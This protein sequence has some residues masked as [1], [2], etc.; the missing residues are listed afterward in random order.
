MT[1]SPVGFICLLGFFFKLGSLEAAPR[2]YTNTQGQKI[3]A[4]IVEVKGDTVILK[5]R[6]KDYPVPINGLSK[7]DQQFISNWAKETSSAS[8][9][10]KKMAAVLGGDFDKLR[11][12]EWPSL[13]VA[14]DDGKDYKMIENE[15]GTF[16]YQSPHFEFHIK[17]EL[18]KSVVK[19]FAR[20]FEATF[21]F[22]D[23]APLG[24]APSPS[25]SGH[26]QTRLFRTRNEYYAA[27]GIQGSG[28]VF[29]YSYRG[30]PDKPAEIKFNK[31]EIK[32]P[33][34]SLGVEDKGTRFVL[35]RDQE[36]KTLIHEI[37][38]QV[39]MRWL[40]VMPTWMSEGFAEFVESQ[41]YS[42]GRYK[43]NNMTSNIRDQIESRFGKQF[44]MVPIEKLMT[45]SSREWAAALGS[46]PQEAGRNYYSA[47]LLLSYFVLL[48]GNQK[49]EGIVG[50]LKAV[51]EGVPVKK[52][53]EDH[54]LR[55]RSY[56]EL[57]VDVQEA[58]RKAERIK[59]VF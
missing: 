8:Q 45:I 39:M 21:Q 6:G 53:T 1:R 31:A 38:H 57:A 27:G 22:L 24:L 13:V 19:E 26:F 47:N 56:E 37:V 12:G 17:V 59:I 35:N 42:Y 46:S 11:L 49:G 16:T 55:G 5:M 7:S 4:E 20:I 15:D 25:G 44:R 50:Y 36:N 30:R 10:G 23:Q 48:D 32:I 29:S 51:S 41:D 58:W 33:M 28:G 2:T 43:L 34:T 52:A 3:V 14:G 9:S 18:S 40:P 54:L